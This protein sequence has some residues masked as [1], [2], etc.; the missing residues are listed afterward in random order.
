[1]RA[2]WGTPRHTPQASVFP[3]TMAVR[4]CV[5]RKNTFFKILKFVAIAGHYDYALEKHSHLLCEIG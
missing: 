2:V 3:L 4:Y 1:M 5:R